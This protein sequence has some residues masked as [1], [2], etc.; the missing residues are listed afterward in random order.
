MKFL[1]THQICYYSQLYLF[2]FLFYLTEV[3]F[4]LCLILA[5]Y[6][7]ISVNSMHLVK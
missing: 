7:K 1:K 5:A 2:I 3:T 6:L 4:K